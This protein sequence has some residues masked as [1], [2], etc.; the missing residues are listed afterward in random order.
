MT[1]TQTFSIRQALDEANP[2]LL[3]QALVQV[4]L[5]KLLTKIKATIA[6]LTATAA[7]VLNTIPASKITI[8]AGP[9]DVVNS[10]ILPPLGQLLTL[11]VTASGTA[12]SLGVYAIGDSGA[13]P[14]IPAGGAGVTT[15][16]AALGDDQVTLTFPNTITGFV[17]EYYAAPG[18]LLQ[19]GVW[20]IV[21]PMNNELGQPSGGI[22]DE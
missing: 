21:N 1:T 5:G 13:T 19:N 12:G 14:A 9:D 7:P 10:G 17:I 2:S 8:N 22:G 3:S 20:T 11:R 15:G 4:R 18:T 6:A 16:V